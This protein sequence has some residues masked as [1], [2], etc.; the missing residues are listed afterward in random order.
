MSPPNGLSQQI[1]SLKEKIEGLKTDI[2]EAEEELEKTQ[3]ELRIAYKRCVKELEEAKEKRYQ[4]LYSAN[5][6]IH[7]L[8]KAIYWDETGHKPYPTGGSSQN[9]GSVE[10]VEYERVGIKVTKY[11]KDNRLIPL[12]SPVLTTVKPYGEQATNLGLDLGVVS[13]DNPNSTPGCGL[14]KSPSLHGCKFVTLDEEQ[15]EEGEDILGSILTSL[16][17]KDGD[18]PLPF[19]SDFCPPP[20]PPSKEE[21][22]GTQ[23][24]K[25]PRG[26][27]WYKLMEGATKEAEQLEDQLSE[28]E[29]EVTSGRVIPKRTT[30]SSNLLANK[31]GEEEL[32]AILGKRSSGTNEVFKIEEDTPLPPFLIPTAGSTSPY[33]EETKEPFARSSSPVFGK[34][35][36]EDPEDDGDD[37]F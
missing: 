28:K 3:R 6:Y 22:N 31:Q 21:G 2:E 37:T 27:N 32:N 9:F 11:G 5:R 8:Q 12:P 30:S 29:E 4:D 20:P 33:G 24:E 26:S 18:Q 16:G 17:R 35:T 14:K 19:P 34:S 36:N 15:K 13:G 23:G 7:T 1:S 25:K 10:S